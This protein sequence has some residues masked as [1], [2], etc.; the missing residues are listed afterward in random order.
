MTRSRK[1]HMGGGIYA[2]TRV[3]IDSTWV[4]QVHGEDVEL[5]Y[6]ANIVLDGRRYVIDDLHIR[7]RPGG[8]AVTGELIRKIPVH[9]IMRRAVVDATEYRENG[10]VS[11]IRLTDSDLKRIVGNGPTDET[12]QWVARL[13]VSGELAGIAPAKNVRSILEIPTSTAG[14]WIRRAKDRGFLDG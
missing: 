7:R 13:Y 5:D 12:L 10:Q 3:R 11:Q 9:H 1:V 4:T 6:S 2:K 14:Y 8:P